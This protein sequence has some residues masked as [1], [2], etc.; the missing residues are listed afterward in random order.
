MKVFIF[1]FLSFIFLFLTEK[2][3]KLLNFYDTPDGFKIHKNKIPNAGGLA[4]IPLVVTMFLVF[5]YDQK[6]TF[7][8]NLFLIVIIIGV[9]DDFNNIN[10]QVNLL[11]L[12]LPI[13]IFTKDVGIVKSL[14]VYGDKNF[15]LGPL[16]FVF[17]LLSIFL[18]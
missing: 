15:V 13:Y 2:L 1:L 9:I 7:S 11:A 3:S 4:L 16:S 5:D 12:L 14:G 6:I 10:P 8:L 18:V 17:T